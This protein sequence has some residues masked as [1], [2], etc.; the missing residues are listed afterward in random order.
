MLFVDRD[1]VVVFLMF[2][3]EFHGAALAKEDDL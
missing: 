3:M 1:V 2:L